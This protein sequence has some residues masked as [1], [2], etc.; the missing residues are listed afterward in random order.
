MRNSLS[1]LSPNVLCVDDE[2]HILTGLKRALSSEFAVAT[3]RSGFEGLEL[4]K[5]ED[6]YA[7]IISDMHMPKM[8]GAEFLRAARDLAPDASRILLTGYADI[9][10]AVEAVNEAGLFRFLL[11]PYPAPRL[12]ETIHAAVEQHRLVTA[13]KEL[14]EK[15]LGGCIQMLTELLALVSPVLPNRALSAQR[16]ARKLATAVGL[17]VAWRL[18]TAAVVTQ[19]ARSTLPA[20]LLATEEAPHSFTLAERTL[21]R[22]C[23][24]I[25]ERLLSPIP[26]LEGVRELLRRAQT[27]P[28]DPHGPGEGVALEVAALILIEDYYLLLELHGNSWGALKALR[29]R[30][31][32]YEPRLLAALEADWQRPSP[33]QSTAVKLD[34]LRP[35]MVLREDVV[36]KQ[37]NQKLVPQGT[38]LT[39]PAL[40]RL[41]NAARRLGVVE[42]IQVAIRTIGET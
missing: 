28:D 21:N 42:P 12:R 20:D 32:A 22:R 17:P 30:A 31:Q 4:L 6:P 27:W 11:K 37:A 26:R 24:E 14:L 3:A 36:A 40:E 38:E 13:E 23:I 33:E 5:A 8:N 25:G 29:A 10:S 7:V 39:R 41:R 15:T 1:I 18:E 2:E 16:L 19:L 35:G 9:D 34:E